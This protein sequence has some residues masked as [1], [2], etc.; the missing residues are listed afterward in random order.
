VGCLAGRYWCTIHVDQEKRKREKNEKNM[1][2]MNVHTVQEK[3]T[4]KDLKSNVKAS[5]HTV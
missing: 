2:V 3:R 1:M 5:N 4:E